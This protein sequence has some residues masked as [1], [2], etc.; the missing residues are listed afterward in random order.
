MAEPTPL[1][2]DVRWHATEEFR[3]IVTVPV[4]ELEKFHD[5]PELWVEDHIT[6]NDLEHYNS[7]AFKAVTD[8]D[9]DWEPLKADSV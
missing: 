6:D 8:R 9:I 4:D 1:K 5:N 3:A 7:H 2:L